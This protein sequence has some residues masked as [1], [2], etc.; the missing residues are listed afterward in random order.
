MR[1]AATIQPLRSVIVQINSIE[2]LDEL[3]TLERDH[4]RQSP[5]YMIAVFPSQ[6]SVSA[7]EHM[8]TAQIFLISEKVKGDADHYNAIARKV[9]DNGTPKTVHLKVTCSAS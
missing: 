6:I 1:I 7:A 8:L 4:S 3:W 9:T 5:I 2:R